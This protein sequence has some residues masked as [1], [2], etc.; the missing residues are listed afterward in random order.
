[1][2]GDPLVAAFD[3]GTAAAEQ[4]Q[5]SL[6]VR[7][8]R[9]VARPCDPTADVP[10]PGGRRRHAP[11][12][13]LAVLKPASRRRRRR[14]GRSG[15]DGRAAIWRLWVVHVVRSPLAGGRRRTRATRSRAW[16]TDP[17]LRCAANA[18]GTRT[19]A[20]RAAA[21]V[22]GPG[23]ASRIGT[24][25]SGSRHAS[26]SAPSGSQGVPRGNHRGVHRRRDDTH[27]GGRVRPGGRTVYRQGRSAFVVPRAAR[28][29]Q[30]GR[31]RRAL[32]PSGAAM[33]R[34]STGS[35][36]P[37]GSRVGCWARIAR[38]AADGGEAVAPR[39]PLA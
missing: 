25:V 28:R 6:D 13:D 37:T 36:R 24:P 4:L 17:S 20:R 21:R 32:V 27:G 11:T 15:P 22:E 5:V 10:A 18:R 34:P 39:Q 30:A 8:Q 9:I 26:P 38:L 19:T 2:H 3:E 12:R 31:L 29:R 23:V 33:P 35:R 14:G 16:A 7:D 1:M